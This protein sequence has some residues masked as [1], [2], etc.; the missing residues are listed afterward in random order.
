M[1]R[2]SKLTDSQWAEVIRRV[3][4]GES[5]ADLCKEFGVSKAAV[6]K[7]VSKPADERKLRVETVANQLL[8]AETSLKAL[9]VGE[10]ADALRLKDHLRGVS[11]GLAAAAS[12]GA[13]VAALFSAIAVTEAQK[14]DDAEPMSTADRVKSC[15]MLTAAANEAAKTGLTLL[16]ANKD[17]AKRAEIAEVPDGLGHFYGEGASLP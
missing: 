7:R 2:P 10:Q 9:P 11:L 4:M 3:S 15:L 16:A 5:Q 1:G 8:A 12:N 17:S 6:S 13:K 14:V